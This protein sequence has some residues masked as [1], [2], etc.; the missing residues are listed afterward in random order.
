MKTIECVILSSCDN[1]RIEKKSLLIFDDKLLVRI[2]Y[3]RLNKIF[4]NI[5]ISTNKPEDYDFL[6]VQKLKDIYPGFVPLSA[7]HSSLTHTAADQVFIVSCNT[8]FLTTSLIYHLLNIQTE[9]LIIVPK[10][11]NIVYHSIGIYS[12]K[13]LPIAEEVLR[14][15]FIAKKIYEEKKPFYFSMKNFVERVGAEIVDVEKEKFYFND[16]FFKIDSLEDYEYVKE[17]LI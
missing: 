9:E 4:D 1:E 7:I 8:P 12:K 10:A 14:A 17:R 6:P 13:I 5:I 16:L 3:E 2:L 15:N 11:K